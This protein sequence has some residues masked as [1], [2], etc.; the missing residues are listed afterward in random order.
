MGFEDLTDAQVAEAL[1]QRRRAVKDAEALAKRRRVRNAGT[2]RPASPDPGP[3]PDS[4]PNL[5]R[6][7][8]VPGGR[9]NENWRV[10]VDGDEL[11]LQF[12]APLN[13]FH[14][15][16]GA[17]PHPKCPPEPRC[18]HQSD[19]LRHFSAKGMSW[20]PTLRHRAPDNQF[21]LRDF[22]P[23]AEFPEVVDND[24]VYF[25]TS[26]Q[27]IAAVSEQLP[28]VWEER[29]ANPWRGPMR[30]DQPMDVA[31]QFA[32]VSRR[33]TFV[34]DF[35]E[36]RNP[37]L[38]AALG[39]TDKV[40]QRVQG[41]RL[42]RTHTPFGL[43]HK[44]FH[45]GQVGLTPDGGLLVIDEEFAAPGSSVYDMTTFLLNDHI[46]TRN[47]EM[48]ARLLD[49]RSRTERAWFRAFAPLVAAG[50]AVTWSTYLVRQLRARSIFEPAT[51]EEPKATLGKSNWDQELTQAVKT[52]NREFTESQLYIPELVAGP[53]KV[54]DRLDE[55]LAQPRVFVFTGKDLSV[56]ADGPK[57]LAERPKYRASLRPTVAPR[58]E[59]EPALPTF[60]AAAYGF[61]QVSK[62][63][64]RP[65]PATRASPGRQRGLPRPDG[66]AATVADADKA[67]GKLAYK[68]QIRNLAVTPWFE[69]HVHGL[70]LE[71]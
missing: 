62:W 31:E 28:R 3:A 19:V 71:P 45:P 65:A 41:R 70:A 53:E 24:D 32:A 66:L 7:R 12:P 25:R 38:L 6:A 60:P 17:Y 46:G 30:G 49:A 56:G 52:L 63:P 57:S 50:N 37:G 44:D 34:I 40:L 54:R 2:K 58:S 33:L 29:D 69:R 8:S 48:T 64:S 10:T 42:P 15:D 43:Q 5:P 9:R 51:H 36:S 20:S 1:A 61:E 68:G 11:L 21:Y 27:W 23:E 67:V 14:L 18:L 22:E 13:T 35:Y 55:Y 39:L 4:D 16:K 26:E 47:P 59:T